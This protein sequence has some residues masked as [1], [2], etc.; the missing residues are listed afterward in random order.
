[1]VTDR[2]GQFLIQ[3]G[4]RRLRTIQLTQVLPT[5]VHL[6]QAEKRLIRSSAGAPRYRPL[7]SRTHSS[8][9]VKIHSLTSDHRNLLSEVLADPQD[10]L[11]EVVDCLFPS[12]SGHRCSAPASALVKERGVAVPEEV[13]LGKVFGDS[14]QGLPEAVPADGWPR[15]ERAVASTGPLGWRPVVVPDPLH[16]SR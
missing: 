12:R 1:M 14:A 7:R 2:K 8:L 13:G 15:S 11:A 4:Q 16:H 6:I 9:K 3:E 10:A 5:Q